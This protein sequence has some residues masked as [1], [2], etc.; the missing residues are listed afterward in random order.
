MPRVVLSAAAV[1]L[2]LVVLSVLSVVQISEHWL[3]WAGP[4]MVIL[5][6]AVKAQ[7][8][9]HHFMEA[10]RARPLWRLLYGLWNLAAAMTI[11][12]GYL[13]TRTGSST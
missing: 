6:A 11:I 5:I 4:I 3:I 1:W 13:L 2:I 9:I 7:L 10:H 8:V 12:V